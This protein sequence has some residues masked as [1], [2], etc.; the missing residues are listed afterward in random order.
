MEIGEAPP[1]LRD[2]NAVVLKEPLHEL[3]QCPALGPGGVNGLP[4]LLLL[5]VEDGLLRR[6]ALLGEQGIFSVQSGLTAPL[7]VVLPVRDLLL[8]PGEQVDL[9]QAPPLTELHDLLPEIAH[10]LPGAAVLCPGPAVTGAVHVGLPLHVIHSEGVDDHVAVEIPGVLMPVGVGADEGDVAG[11]VGLAELL[12]HLLYLLQRQA[13]VGPVTG[14]EGED[15]VVGLDV[16][17]L[18]VLVVVEVCFQAIQGK[19]VRGTADAGDQVCLSGDVVAFLIQKGPLGLLIVL[20]AEI[21]RCGGVVGVFTGN[22]FNDGHS[23]C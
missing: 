7:C 16:S 19:A 21:E 13:V 10:E 15:V 9:V 17:L 2:L 4:Q 12:P 8:R 6:L 5:G 14:V 3:L 22:V 18:P 23:G 20:K 1:A 11:E